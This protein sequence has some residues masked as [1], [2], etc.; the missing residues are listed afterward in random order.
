M[1]L[2]KETPPDGAVGRAERRGRTSKHDQIA[3]DLRADPYEWYRVGEYSSASG[4]TTANLIRSGK[5]P[6]KDGGPNAYAPAGDFEA[7]AD[8]GVVWARYVGS[9]PPFE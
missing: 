6:G 8:Q 1:V 5:R 7:V 4:A 9:P 3:A 2:V